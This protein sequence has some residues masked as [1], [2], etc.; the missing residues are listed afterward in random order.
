MAAAAEEGAAARAEA[1][2]RAA[3]PLAPP[4][5][6]FDRA[7]LSSGADGGVAREAL[8]AQAER[9]ARESLAYTQPSLGGGEEEKLSRELA[10]KQALVDR[11]L[12]D[13]E[14]RSVAVAR[15]NEE[16]TNLRGSNNH[17]HRELAALRAHLAERDSAVAQLAADTTN[18]DNIDSNEL[19]RRHRLLGAAYR[20]DRRKMEQML[21]QQQTM[22]AALAAHEQLHQAHVELKEAHRQQA[23]QMQ[24]LQDEVRRA[25]EARRV[26]EERSGR[27]RAATKK[28]EAIIVRFE[29]LLGQAAKKLESKKLEGVKLEEAKRQLEPEMEALKSKLQQMEAELQSERGKPRVEPQHEAHD[30]APSAEAEEQVR[31]LVRTEKSERRAAALEEEMMEMSRLHAREVASLKLKIAE[32]DAQLMGGFGSN[33]N[34]ELGE[35]PTAPAAVPA[36]ER[37]LPPRHPSGGSRRNSPRLNPLPANSSQPAA[38]QDARAVAQSPTS[39]R[40]PEDSPQL[41]QFATQPSSEDIVPPPS[42]NEPTGS[43]P[44]QSSAASPPVVSLPS[45]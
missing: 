1:S 2:E 44:A 21:E 30:E 9:A 20:T 35:L 4:P 12:D 22:G 26:A 5:M 38:K 23:V 17:L 25:E 24:R 16:L 39:A 42:T 34:L 45:Q 43:P 8:L 7:P 3:A 33:A 15:C 13:V 19:R 32:K 41:Q 6:G 18:T 14:R 11:L 40:E 37:A 10:H 28:Q 31:L 36:A 27:Y 29:A